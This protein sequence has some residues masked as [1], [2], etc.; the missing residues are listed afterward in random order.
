MSTE[1]LPSEAEEFLRQLRLG[2]ATLPQE[3]RDDIIAE[4]R[5]HLRD[6]HAK[7]K[8][9]LLAGFEDAQ[10]YASRFVSEMALRGALARGTSVELG[11]A[12]LTGAATGIAMLLTVVP[13]V[14]VQL[15]GGALVIAG[16]LKP[17]MPSRV[18]LFVDMEGKFVA[19]GACGGD[20]GILRE[21]LGFWAMPLFIIGGICFLWLG[22]RALRFLANRRLISVR[23]RPIE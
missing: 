20:V 13:L 15:L 8:S 23:S 12:L 10:T 14:I 22:N 6:R 4:V 16:A 9:P 3:E 17:F 1:T 5:S 7:G 19:L 2:L 21:L 18:G 11:K